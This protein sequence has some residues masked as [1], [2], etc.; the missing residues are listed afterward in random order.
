M[1][2]RELAKELRDH[3][4]YEHPIATM[5]DSELARRLRTHMPKIDL[6]GFLPGIEQADEEVE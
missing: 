1:W 2:P 6:L 4:G 5:S 3:L